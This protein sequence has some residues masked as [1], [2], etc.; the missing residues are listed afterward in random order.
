[1][2]PHLFL[3][4]I[5]TLFASPVYANYGKMIAD[6]RYEP[7]GFQLR[8]GFKDVRLAIETARELGAP[9]P[10]ANLLH[11]RLLQ[12]IAQ[13]DGELDWTAIAK[14]SARNSGL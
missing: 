8:L 6:Q 2:D 5:N 9:M 3:E 11:D 1:V 4:I 7:A 12:A 14:V 10:L 13:G